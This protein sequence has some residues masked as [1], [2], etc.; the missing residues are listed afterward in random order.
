VFG[1]GIAGYVGDVVGGWTAICTPDPTTAG[2]AV[3][4]PRVIQIVMAEVVFAGTPRSALRCYAL[5]V[6]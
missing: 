6:R 2:F 4:Y 3:R 5:T 1:L